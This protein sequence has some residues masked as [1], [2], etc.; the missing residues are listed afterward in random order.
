MKE[1]KSRIKLIS[2]LS[3]EE[4][5]LLISKLEGSIKI[6]ETTEFH[7]SVIGGMSSARKPLIKLVEFRA[8]K[9]TKCV[10][11]KIMPPI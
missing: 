1:H 6:V 7:Q 9:T 4:I 2:S 10:A 5:D 8:S 11:N 3:S